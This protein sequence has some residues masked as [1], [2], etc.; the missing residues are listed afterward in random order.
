MKAPSQ[1]IV[2]P[3]CR[4][5]EDSREEAV[6]SRVAEARGGLGRNRPLPP[7]AEATGGVGRNRPPPR[8]GNLKGGEGGGA[9]RPPVGGKGKK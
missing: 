8:G 1:C 3:A 9:D 4:S 2:A 7:V 5:L 6:P